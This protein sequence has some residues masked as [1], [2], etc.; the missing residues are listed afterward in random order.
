MSPGSCDEGIQNNRGWR[1]ETKQCHV[2]RLNVDKLLE[3]TYPN[4][5][6]STSMV[7][8]HTIVDDSLTTPNGIGTSLDAD[9]NTEITTENTEENTS[10]QIDARDEIEAY[11]L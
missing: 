9:T 5:T 8:G 1:T 6:L 4:E 2:S 10:Y 7:T 3:L 11:T